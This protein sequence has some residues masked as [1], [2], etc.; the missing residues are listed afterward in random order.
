MLSVEEIIVHF[1]IV[2]S[3]SLIG[4]L[5]FTTIFIVILRWTILSSASKLISDETKK[6]IAIWL[7]EVVRNG[8]ADSL[9]DPKIKKIVEEILE[10]IRERLK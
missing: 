6:K 1:C 7:Q 3:A 4:S 5:I 8:I 2:V 10:L 9:H